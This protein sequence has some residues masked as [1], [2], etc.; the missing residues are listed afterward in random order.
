M[1]SRK[2]NSDHPDDAW[3]LMI[4]GISSTGMPRY[5]PP[6]LTGKHNLLC[7]NTGTKSSSLIPAKILVPALAAFY[8]TNATAARCTNLQQT[9]WHGFLNH[10][11]I[12]TSDM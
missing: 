4:T 5:Q 6:I 11:L 7:K 8:F 1:S 10:S 12:Q 9:L 2:K 3:S